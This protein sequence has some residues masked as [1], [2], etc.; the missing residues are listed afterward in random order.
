MNGYAHSGELPELSNERECFR[1]S[2][3]MIN[4]VLMRRRNPDPRS[5]LRRC[6]KLDRFTIPG[7]FQSL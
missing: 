2:M 5:H 6:R 4:R 7:P 1:G 3:T